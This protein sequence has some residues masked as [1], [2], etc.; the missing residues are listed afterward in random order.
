[1]RPTPEAWT[2]VVNPAAGRRRARQRLPR[3][4]DALAQSGLDVEVR[5]SRDADDLIAIAKIAY[6]QVVSS[7]G[8]D[9]M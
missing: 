6:R 7:R 9:G 5:V 4:M 2:A 8:G 3:V 1:M